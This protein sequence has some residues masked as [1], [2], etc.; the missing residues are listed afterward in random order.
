MMTRASRPDDAEDAPDKPHISSDIDEPFILTVREMDWKSKVKL[1]WWY[2]AAVDDDSNARA[3][4]RTS[5]F[6]AQFF[7]FDRAPRK[8]TFQNDRDI[9]S[10]A[11][12]L[13]E[14]L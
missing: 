13:V 1:M 12:T 14:G 5:D 3:A 11:I 2:I 8:L 6:K 7:G 9:L 10:K 4:A